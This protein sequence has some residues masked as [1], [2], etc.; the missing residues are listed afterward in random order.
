MPYFTYLVRCNDESYYCGYTTDL[1]RRVSEH[2]TSKKASK[3]IKPR[4]P[5]ELVYSRKFDCLS[6][7]LK[8]EITLKKLSHNQKAKLV[9]HNG[10]IDLS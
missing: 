9:K 6:K 1:A 5:V 10:I 4:R 3:Y 8:Y 7:A 2:N